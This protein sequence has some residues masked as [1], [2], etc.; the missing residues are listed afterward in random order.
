MPEQ[1]LEPDRNRL[2]DLVRLTWDS[3]QRDGEPVAVEDQQIADAGPYS[4]EQIREHLL[5][6]Q[7]TTYELGNEGGSLSVLRVR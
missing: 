6:E 1:E 7:G 4:L 3:A 2:H 5:D